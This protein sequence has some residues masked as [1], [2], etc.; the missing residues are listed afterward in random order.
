[1]HQINYSNTAAEKQDEAQSQQSS[2]TVNWTINIKDPI[3]IRFG[4]VL[5]RSS[6]FLEAYSS[7]DLAA[8]FKHKYF[9]I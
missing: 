9:K 7:S 4:I 8:S 3:Q 1:M 5:H 6:K 2:A